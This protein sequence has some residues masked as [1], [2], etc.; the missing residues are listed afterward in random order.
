MTIAGTVY[1]RM[2]PID[3]DLQIA[4]V[5]HPVVG[6]RLWCVGCTLTGPYEFFCQPNELVRHIK[7]HL[8][9]PSQPP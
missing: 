6:E 1:R 7:E 2:G 5:R 8:Q 3:Q 4:L 9:V